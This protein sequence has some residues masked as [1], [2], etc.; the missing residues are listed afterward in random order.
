MQ[1]IL[2]TFFCLIACLLSC[3]G[4]AQQR[5]N[6]IIIY[7]DDLG[8]GDLSCYGATKI[9]T[10]HIDRL[11]KQGLRFSDGH[12][13]SATCTPSRYGLMTGIYPWRKQGTG[14]LPGDA[15]LIIDTAQATLPKIFKEAGY[16]T[17]I[18]GKWHLGLGTAVEKAWNGWLTP[19][20]NECGFDQSFI[21][22][23]TADRVP[24]V[25]VENHRVVA[26][27]SLDPIAVNYHQKI[28]NDPTG[29]EHPELL[30][31]LSSPGQGHDQ[32]IV[33]GIGRIGYMSGGKRARWADEELSF[34]FLSKVQ[35]FISQQSG[36]P[37]FMY[38][39]AT[40]PHVPRMPATIF[41]NKS[42]LG[43]RGD[44][45]LELDWTV[46]QIL[47]LLDRLGIAKNTIVI[48]TSDN[49]PVLDDGYQDGAVT[50]LNGHTP[51]GKWRGGKYSAY[52]G[53]TRVPWLIRW[54][55]KIQA[56]V[57]TATISQ[58][59]LLRSFAAFLQIHVPGSEAKDSKDIMTSLL[60]KKKTGR[61]WL[62]EQGGPIAIRKGNWKLILPHKGP[63]FDK[64]TH[65]EIGNMPDP[66]LYNLA[67]D[68][69]EKNNIAD[70]Y[71]DKVAE[72][73]KLLTG[74]EE[75]P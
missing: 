20:P 73:R 19:G 29:K 9:H 52:E 27:D 69:G 10:P 3:I 46:G 41:K 39:A 72:L 36:Q 26:L 7:A 74:I 42:G 48:F 62:V 15:A 22:P 56:G 51:A 18:V 66:Q 34:T 31:L 35:A 38:Y 16:R 44:A 6:V 1:Q 49:G 67:T 14:V 65:T 17:A 13:T 11:A 32:T 8:Y 24:T 59:D 58:V 50:M 43:Y 30:K 75:Q 21:F 28:G 47:D 61:D 64:L 54:P 4:Y 53:G 57:S 5:P 68:P 71:P 55:G 40:E 45:I 33:N 12:C 37:F 60:G 63:F 2:R 23:A 70:K 25:F